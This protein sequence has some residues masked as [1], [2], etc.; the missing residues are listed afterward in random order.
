MTQVMNTQIYKFTAFPYKYLRTRTFQ[1][2][3]LFGKWF[4]VV[5][6]CNMWFDQSIFVLYSLYLY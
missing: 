5:V 3:L 1:R 4:Q 6:P 2:T